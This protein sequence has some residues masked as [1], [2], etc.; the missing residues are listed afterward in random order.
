MTKAI[1]ST[2]AQRNAATAHAETTIA[3]L[4]MSV[5]DNTAC[6]ASLHLKTFNLGAKEGQRSVFLNI[7]VL[8]LWVDILSVSGVGN[9][10]L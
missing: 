5:N 1:K 6:T 7:A 3:V 9:M 2:H 4:A 10:H 8:W